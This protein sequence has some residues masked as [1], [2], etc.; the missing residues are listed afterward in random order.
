[1][2]MSEKLA[3]QARRDAL[4]GAY[5]RRYLT[6]QLDYQIST[7]FRTEQPFSIVSI[8]IDHFKRINDQHGHDIGDVVLKGIS[9][10]MSQTLREIDIYGRWGGEEFLCILPNTDTE[11]AL[12]CAERLRNN[13]KQA[14]FNEALSDLHVT[15]SFGV[16]STH[17]GDSVMDMLKRADLALYQSKTQ[18]RDQVR[19]LKGIELS[20]KK[21]TPNWQKILMSYEHQI[22]TSVSL[23]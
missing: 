6:E 12:V 19:Y 22:M 7:Y 23:K 14:Q 1:M 16:T 3:E 8:D 18:G 9:H 15:A 13:V 4:T 21:C 11:E 5:N 17:H 2:E 10:V 20:Q